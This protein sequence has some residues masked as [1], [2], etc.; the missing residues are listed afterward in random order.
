MALT[1]EKK[2]RSKA[3]NGRWSKDKQDRSQ[4]SEVRLEACRRPS[5]VMCVFSYAQRKT[6][7]GMKSGKIT[8]SWLKV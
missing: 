8:E 1:A 6:W 4:S 7:R 2:K 3:K 5:R